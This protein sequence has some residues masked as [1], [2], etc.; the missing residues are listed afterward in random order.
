MV[1]YVQIFAQLCITFP[2]GNA[3]VLNFSCAFFV[4]SAPLQRVRK[5]SPSFPTCLTYPCI[6]SQLTRYLLDMFLFLNLAAV[7]QLD[8][9]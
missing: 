3:C 8:P 6:T 7:N 2:A 4:A 1:F 9:S 5:E